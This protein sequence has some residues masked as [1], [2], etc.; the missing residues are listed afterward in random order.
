MSALQLIPNE[1]VG[2]RIKPDWY[3]FNVALVKRHGAN[4]KNAGQEYEKTIAYCKDV[5]GAMQ[6]IL[7]HSV[8][9]RVE[10][11]QA[12]LAQFES[13]VAFAQDFKAQFDAALQDAL[14]AAD[15]LQ[16]RIQALSL[17][18]KDLVRT[19]GEAVD[20]DTASED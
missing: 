14:T 4:S 11:A 1:I 3:S 10:V 7:S 9:V 20:T 2:Y 15:E 17:S 18:Q 12:D 8:R 5:H 16:A 6:F 13:S 19:L